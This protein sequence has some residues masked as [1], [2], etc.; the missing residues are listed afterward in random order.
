VS[1]SD[2]FGGGQ[3]LN[4]DLPTMFSIG[5]GPLID[6]KNS[7]SKLSQPSLIQYVH[8]HMFQSSEI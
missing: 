6:T 3:Y 2:T 4:M 5:R 1:V 8:N 7:K